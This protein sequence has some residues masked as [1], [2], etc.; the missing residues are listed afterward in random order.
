[1]F[2][3][4]TV[5]PVGSPFCRPVA[6]GRHDSSHALPR[7]L[8]AMKSWPDGLLLGFPNLRRPQPFDFAQGRLLAAVRRMGTP[9]RGAHFVR[10]FA[11]SRRLSARLKSC[12]FTNL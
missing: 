10:T 7:S 1:M 5:A 11:S 8:R 9:V 6:A 4:E 12:P 2:V 3:S